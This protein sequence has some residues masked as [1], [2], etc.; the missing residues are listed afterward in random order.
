MIS[1][2][3]EH[4][5]LST[6]CLSCYRFELAHLNSP[7]NYML[8]W[9]NDDDFLLRWEYKSLMG[10]EKQAKVNWKGTET[11]LCLLHLVL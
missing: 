11:F 10:T 5:V 9:A 1:Y 3:V 7:G 8:Y 2:E 4:L 6:L